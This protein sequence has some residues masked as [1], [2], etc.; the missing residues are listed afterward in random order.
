VASAA[1]R[2]GWVKAGRVEV[3]MP[4][5]TA[6]LML[7]ETDGVLTRVSLFGTALALAE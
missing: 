3:L 6:P 7:Q 1:W 2:V 5:G 4:G